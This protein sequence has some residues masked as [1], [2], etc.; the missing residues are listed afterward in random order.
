MTL[1][2]ISHISSLVYVVP[3][4]CSNFTIPQTSNKQFPK[5]LP[6]LHASVLRKLI[7]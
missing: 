4:I 7:G 3:M 5:C 1:Y 2:S 6:S